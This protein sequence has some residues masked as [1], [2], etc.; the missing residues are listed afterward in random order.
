MERGKPNLALGSLMILV[1]L[2]ALSLLLR[3]ERGLLGLIL[4]GVLIV[5]G[6]YWFREIKKAMK[7]EHIH[8][9][10]LLEV[11]E[12]G[13]WIS[14]TA[15]VPGPEDAVSFEVLGKKLLLKGGKGFKKVIKLPYKVEIL[16]SSYINGIL[17]LELAKIE[18]LREKRSRRSY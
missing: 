9:D 6:F 2:L 13:D 16:N 4:T 1:I 15:Q 11:S 5:L 8:R 18:A 3:L 12:H 14:L 17:H 7:S 10:Y